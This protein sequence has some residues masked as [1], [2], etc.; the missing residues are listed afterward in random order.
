VVVGR[1]LIATGASILACGLAGAG[2]SAA[3]R[4]LPSAVRAHSVPVA[5]AATT[6]RWLG[7]AERQTLDRVFGG[8]RPV[9]TQ[10]I[11]YAKKIAVVWVFD[12]VVICG[13]CSAPS[14]ASL[15]RGR[16]IRVSYDRSTH[17]FRAA[18]GMRFCEAH[19]SSPPLAECPRR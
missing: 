15:P 7:S 3:A 1:S 13:A 10:L 19:G 5:I 8:A 4:S 14:N 9:H 16:V 2:A 6:P 12:R 11:P 17:L 18:D